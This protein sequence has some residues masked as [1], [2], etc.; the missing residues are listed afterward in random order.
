MTP[1]SAQAFIKPDALDSTRARIRSS[2]VILRDTLHSVTSGSSL[3]QRDLRSG[4]PAI[5][6]SRVRTI[7]RAC[8]N[9]SRIWSD[10]R[11]GLL[12]SP[13]AVT[14]PRQVRA[15]LDQ[16]LRE[17]RE[18]LTT[19]SSEFDELAAPGHV[20]DIRDHATPRALKAQTAV[21]NFEE[22][23][24]HYL[25]SLRITVRP[26]GAGPSPFASGGTQ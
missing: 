11:D 18:A 25:A 13:A 6:L 21:R 17:L 22:A 2:Y 9:G 5:L 7:G 26:R 23:A 19:C 14:V 24:R 12:E 8:R 10:S 15:A 16:R 20:Q 4:S 1:A 3:L